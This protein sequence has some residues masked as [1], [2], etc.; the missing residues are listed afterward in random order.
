VTP[1][2]GRAGVT[3]NC[4]RLEALTVLPSMGAPA[5]RACEVSG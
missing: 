2:E 3:A 4:G 1:V 5:L